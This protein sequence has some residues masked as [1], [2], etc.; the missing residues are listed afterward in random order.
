M[1]IYA[2][3]DLH[4]SFDSSGREHKPM[5]IFGPN[6][7][8][9]SEKIAKNWRGVVRDEDTVLVLGDTSWAL[10]LEEAGYDLEF[11]AA[12]PGRKILLKGNHDL[13]WQSLTKLR[14]A[15]PPG[16][17]FI[18]NNHY[19][20]DDGTAIVGT[21]GWLVPG[22]A[23]FTETDQKTYRR[24]LNR[25]RLSIESLPKNGMETIACMHYPPFN[26]RNEPS[27]FIDI[28]REYDITK[29]V[30]AHLHGP[31]LKQELPTNAWGVEL[32]L[33]SADAIDFCPILVSG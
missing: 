6:W 10:R 20:L 21:R 25:L 14:E 18:Q 30:Y 1:K 31:S 17:E 7:E 8:N 4:L 12:L 2:L 22:D 32:I 11:L 13:W 29:C 5:G 9:H 28:L 19:I 26:S 3:G 27:E 33:A 16:L 24:E 15:A 23:G